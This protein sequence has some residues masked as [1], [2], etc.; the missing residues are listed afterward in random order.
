MRHQN[1]A[2][3][4]LNAADDKEQHQRDSHNDLTVQHRDVRN[5]HE[6]RPA[7]FDMLLMPMHASVPRMVA[8]A[9]ARS[10]MINVVYSAFMISVLANSERYQC[11]VKPPH[12]AR[13]LMH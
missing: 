8:I 7:F 12:L 11:S 5:T 1:R 2:E 9:E 10:A 6:K 13:V 4:K 3:S